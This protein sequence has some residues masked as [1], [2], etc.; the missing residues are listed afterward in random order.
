M[1]KYRESDRNHWVSRA[2]RANHYV[3]RALREA[4]P[5]V[6][7]MYRADIDEYMARARAA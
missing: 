3:L 4:L 6:A 2:R 7:E 5:G 1:N